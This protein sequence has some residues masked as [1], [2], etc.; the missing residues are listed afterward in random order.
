M[1]F[2]KL[3]ILLFYVQR[4]P[5]MTDTSLSMVQLSGTVYGLNC[6]HRKCHWMSLGSTWRCFCFTD[7]RL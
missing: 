3:V 1:P 7:C 5:I 2:V 6:F 4:Q